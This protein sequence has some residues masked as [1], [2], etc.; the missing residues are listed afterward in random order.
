MRSARRVLALAG[1]AVFA[2][3]ACG[4]GREPDLMQVRSSRSGPADAIV[5]L[6]GK[7]QASGVSS[8]A[9]N[10]LRSYAA[11]KGVTPS[12]RQELASEDLDYRKKNRGRVLQRLFGS[13]LYSQAYQPQSLDRYAELER[14]RK[15]GVKTPS[16]PEPELED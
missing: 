6:G 8:A 4:S 14:W 15:R 9:D 12:I 13:N 3:S 11:R 1:V 7:P 16:A 10:A 2:L 5:A